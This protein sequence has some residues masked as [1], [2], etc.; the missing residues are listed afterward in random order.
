MDL[1]RDPVCRRALARAV[2]ASGAWAT[3][4]FVRLPAE[5]TPPHPHTPYPP[6]S[7]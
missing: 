4:A 1:A 5:V 2:R 7:S 6:P 3:T